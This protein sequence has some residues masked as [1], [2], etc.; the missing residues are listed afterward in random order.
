M[1]IYTFHV[2]DP[3]VPTTDAADP[4]DLILVYDASTGKTSRM[5][6]GQT[7]NAA[8]TTETTGATLSNNGISILST[9]ASNYL[10]AAPVKGQRKIVTA[11]TPTTV[12]KVLLSSTDGTITFGTSVSNVFAFSTVAI[13]DQTVEL[14][15]S[16]TTKWV[17]VATAGSTAVPSIATSTST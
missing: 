13:L 16:S 7:Q 3:A 4:T 15:G 5:F 9:V 1:S 10:L 14:I 11:P 6:L 12:K 2:Q 17:I 8:I